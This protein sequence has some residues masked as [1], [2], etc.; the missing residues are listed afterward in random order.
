MLRSLPAKRDHRCEHQAQLADIAQQE[1]PH[2]SEGLPGAS[3]V[4]FWK[5]LIRRRAG[6]RPPPDRRVFRLEPTADGCRS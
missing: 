5:F 2:P 4:F 6:F 1:I 3:D